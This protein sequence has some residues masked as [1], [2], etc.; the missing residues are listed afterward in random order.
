MKF[1]IERGVKKR[2]VKVVIYG[3][4]GVGK[5]T[6]AAKFPNPLFI[7][8]E[9]GG[10]SHVDVARLPTP[11]SW[12]MLMQEVEA[13]IAD[14]EG[15]QTLVIDTADWAEKLCTAAVC[16]ERHVSGIE[17]IGYGKGY[18][19]IKE[20]FGK[21]L[22]SLDKLIDKDV[23]VLIL[24][25]AIQ[26]KVELPEETGAYDHWEMKLHQKQTAPLVK[27]WAD[28]LLFYTFKPTV[29]TVGKGETAKAKATTEKRVIFTEHR[30]TADAKNRFGLPEKIEPT[31]KDLAPLLANTPNMPA[32]TKQEAPQNAQETGTAKPSEKKEKPV[33]RPE[34]KAAEAMPEGFREAA[35]LAAMDAAEAFGVSDKD[36]FAGIDQRLADLMRADGL[37]PWHIE[38]VCQAKGFTAMDQKTKDF[39]APLVNAIIKQWD[40]IAAKAKTIKE[41]EELPL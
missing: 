20:M 41:K 7:D 31:M 32:R 3:P 38:A 36:L 25:H 21:L 35:G 14:P 11:S 4:E 5:T 17:D 28:A 1:P 12:Q 10:T 37:L 24:A 9:G 2:A 26:R 15:F 34:S 23:N 22:N 6:L 19:Y 39:P 13:V 33:E 29:V 8:T 30:A 40:K 18:V 16:D 27:E